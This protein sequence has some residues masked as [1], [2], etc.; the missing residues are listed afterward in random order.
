MVP[1]ANRFLTRSTAALC[2]VLRATRRRSAAASAVRQGPDLMHGLSL[3]LRGG[4]AERCSASRLQSRASP[5]ALPVLGALVRAI[6]TP[7][8]LSAAAG[9][10][11]E[12]QQ[13]DLA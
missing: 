11:R 13:S 12:C 10:L 9:R 1:I 2:S 4:L 8:S 7:G 6:I 3:P 5:R